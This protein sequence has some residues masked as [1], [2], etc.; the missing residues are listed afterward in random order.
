MGFGKPRR[1]DSRPLEWELDTRLNIDSSKTGKWH[2][3]RGTL[4]R[5]KCVGIHVG[6]VKEREDGGGESVRA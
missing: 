5:N 3:P 1:E 2:F 6:G 4:E